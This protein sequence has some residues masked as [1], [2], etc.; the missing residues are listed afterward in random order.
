MEPSVTHLHACAST[1]ADSFRAS[2]AL[3]HCTHAWATAPGFLIAVLTRVQSCDTPNIHNKSM[4]VVQCYVQA[5]RHAW[6]ATTKK[7][8]RLII[9]AES[10]AT[11]ENKL[12]LFPSDLNLREPLCVPKLWFYHLFA[13]Q[14]TWWQI[15][16]SNWRVTFLGDLL[17]F[18]HLRCPDVCLAAT[19]PS[20]QRCL[21]LSAERLSRATRQPPDQA[22]RFFGELLRKPFPVWVILQPESTWQ[23]GNVNVTLNIRKQQSTWMPNAFLPAAADSFIPRAN[24]VVDLLDNVFPSRSHVQWWQQQCAVIPSA[25]KYG[26][27]QI[28]FSS[29]QLSM[30]RSWK[31]YSE[32]GLISGWN[33]SPSAFE[34]QLTQIWNGL[35]RN[36]NCL[37]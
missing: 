26:L 25:Q 5:M 10:P 35:L 29:L 36:S 1:H 18:T 31:A 27:L 11:S 33:F 23:K 9:L 20:L 14:S 4:L 19:R 30:S 13:S 2:R 32:Y 15:S 22:W 34:E 16:P 3:N 6:F 21:A 8:R 17:V 7:M 28:S 24:A 37:L 12:S